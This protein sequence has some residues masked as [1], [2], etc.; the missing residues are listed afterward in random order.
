M[1]LIYALTVALGNTGKAL[2][3]FLLVIQISSAG[4]SYPLQLL[5]GWFQS[6]SPW[7]PATYAIDAFRGAIAGIYEADY[8]I[9]LGTLLLFIIPALI[10]GV[11]LRKPLAKYTSSL[12]EALA[13]TKMM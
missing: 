10:L 3:V 11:V 1:L 7:L 2:A 6:I 8:W 4:G 9:A 12:N 13:K 5:P